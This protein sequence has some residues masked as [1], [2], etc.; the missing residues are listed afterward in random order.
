M[1]RYENASMRETPTGGVLAAGLLPGSKGGTL[2]SLGVVANWDSRDN[3]F[4]TQ[5]G[6]FYQLT[7]LFYR[8]AFGSDYSFDDIQFDG[9]NFF[10]SFSDHVIA[11]Q[12]AAEFIDGVAPFQRYARFG[13][14]NL[15]RGYFDGRYRDKNGVLLQAE[16]RMPVWWRFG[17]VGFAGVAQVAD[18]VSGFAIDRFWFAGG[19]GLRFAWNPEEKINIRLDYGAGKNSSGMYFTITEAF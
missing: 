9:R 17:V 1:V 6:S 13:G 19:I 10:K 3:T 2:A 5:S 12:A 16:Y 15:L 8:S 14:Q 11:V 4:A 18:Q 7:A